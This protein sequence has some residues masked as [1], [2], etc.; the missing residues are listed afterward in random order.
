MYT[1]EGIGANVPRKSRSH[2]LLDLCHR[3]LGTV[4][5][6]GESK[7]CISTPT[8]T[9]ALSHSYVARTPVGTSSIIDVSLS[10]LFQH[11][12]Q[13]DLTRGRCA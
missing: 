12:V 3:Y 13:T 7:S 2:A 4:G 10:S 8:T 1:Q 5:T 11:V 6:V 9:E